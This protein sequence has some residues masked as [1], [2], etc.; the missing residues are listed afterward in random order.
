WRTLCRSAV[1]RRMTC[2]L[3]AISFDANDPVRLA[4]FWGGLLSWEMADDEQDGVALLPREGTGFGFGFSPT[5]DREPSQ[6]QM[7]FHLTSTSDEDQQHTVARALELGAKHIDV[8]DQ[9]HVVLADP[10]G[11]EFCVIEPGNKFLAGCG[12]F[13]EVSC[14]GSQQVGYFWSAAL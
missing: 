1:P 7:H 14:E 4:R 8:G 13:A 2:H 10:G 12:F 3:L 5:Q 9:P 6:K 11:N